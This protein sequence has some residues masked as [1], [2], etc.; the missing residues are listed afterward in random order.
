MNSNKMFPLLFII[1]LFL[2]LSALFSCTQFAFENPLDPSFRN[3]APPGNISASRGTF[4]YIRVT[5]DIMDYA[6]EYRIT[7]SCDREEDKTIIITGGSQTCYLDH[8]VAAGEIYYY[9][10]QALLSTGTVTALSKSAEGYRTAAEPT[11]TVR[12]K[13]GSDEFYTFEDRTYKLGEQSGRGNIV[14]IR[15]DLDNAYPGLGLQY[16]AHF[17]G[18]GNKGWFADGTWLES[19]TATCYTEAFAVETRG[20]QAAGYDIFYQADGEENA[21]FKNGELCGTTGASTVISSL[22]IWIEK[23]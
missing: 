23:K 15:I 5:W 11:L 4:N 21:V 9:R 6:M 10:V 7:R 12:F 2:F 3:G 8:D 14:G 16:R 22:K 18:L 19:R 17:S 1:I 20:G 13:T